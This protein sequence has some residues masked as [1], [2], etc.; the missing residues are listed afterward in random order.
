MTVRHPD[1][2]DEL[3][4]GDLVCF[5]GGPDGAHK[6]TNSGDGT[7]RM[8]I[9]ST[10]NLPAVAVYPDSDK[11]G[12]WTEGRRDNI[13]VRRESGVDYYDREVYAEP[14]PGAAQ[15]A[16]GGAAAGLQPARRPA[17]LGGTIA[18]P[19]GQRH[20]GRNIA[21]DVVDLAHRAH[22]APIIGWNGPG[23]RGI[24][25][26]L[27]ANAR[28]A[29]CRTPEQSLRA[30]HVPARIALRRGRRRGLRRPRPPAGRG[31]R[32]PGRGRRLRGLR[33]RGDDRRRERRGRAR[34]AARRSST[35]PA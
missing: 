18:P 29:I 5:P 23:P 25:A 20:A 35:R 14:R 9:V 32:R 28:R 27:V 22:C 3:E 21:L 34:R 6:L 1:G 15:R 4:A 16:D 24:R 13:M 31:R 19:L 10:N 7:A 2:E 12:V 33:L 17:R 11:I 26:Y 8:L 30:W